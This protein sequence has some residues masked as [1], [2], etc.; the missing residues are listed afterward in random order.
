M[1]KENILSVITPVSCL[2]WAQSP[3]LLFW[4]EIEAEHTEDFAI[5]STF[6]QL[7][8]QLEN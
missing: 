4:S 1:L 2:V 8:L 5:G 7:Q 6:A 3:F